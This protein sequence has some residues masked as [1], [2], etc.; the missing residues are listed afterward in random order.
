MTLSYLFLPSN[1]AI[2]RL[3][4]NGHLAPSNDFT[5]KKNNKNAPS[6]NEEIM[7]FGRIDQKIVLKIVMRFFLR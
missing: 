2:K 4:S 7:L 1:K 5:L 3:E 6:N